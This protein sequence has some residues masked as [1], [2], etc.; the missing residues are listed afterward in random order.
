MS[1]LNFAN[2]RYAG[3]AVPATNGIRYDAVTLYDSRP[4]LT[5]DNISIP[6]NNGG[7]T[8]GVQA[9]ISADF[10]SFRQDD[11]ASG[12]LVRQTTV[13][14]YSLNGI[15]VRPNLVNGLTGLAQATNAMPYPA[16]PSTLGGNINYT[17]DSPLP[18]ILTSA[19]IGGQELL[20]G[21]GGTTQFVN[22]RIYIQPGMMFKAEKG[23]SLDIVNNA[24][25]INIGSRTYIN[26]FD[27]NP[28]FVVDPT[29]TWASRPRSWR[30]TP[31]SSSPRSS[32]TRRPPRT[33]T[34]SP[35]RRRSWSRR[36]T[37]PT[38]GASSSRLRDR[39]FATARPP[40]VWPT[41]RPSGATSRSRPAPSPWS[42]TPR[43]S[44]A[45]ARSTASSRRSPTNRSWPSSPSTRRSRRR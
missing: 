42:T 35:R 43:S 29:K 15:W 40:P 6:Q 2:V 37:R 45:A 31:R 44:M 32:T 39:S 12:P 18:Y 8:N 34:R 11:T 24:A 41:T 20:V 4:A 9:A 5:N 25:S 30:A 23:A 10:D 36:S 1:I 14:N 33:S 38:P 27:A 28:N 22:N 21:T 7:S 17:F 13:A 16:N 19:M 3:G 26:Q